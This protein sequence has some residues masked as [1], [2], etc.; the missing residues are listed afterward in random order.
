MCFQT[1]RSWL[2]WKCPTV[3]FQESVEVNLLCQIEIQKTRHFLSKPVNKACIFYFN[4]SACTKTLSWFSHLTA[5]Q[6]IQM[7]AAV[8]WPLVPLRQEIDGPQAEQLQTVCC[9]LFKKKTKPCLD[10]NEGDWVPKNWCFWTV[11]LEKTLKNPLDCKEVLPVHPNG[12]Q[13][14]IFIGRTH[15]EAETPILWS[16]HVKSWLTGKDPDAGRDWGQEEKGTT[17]DE[18]AG[19]HHRLDGR[20]FEWTPGVGDGQGG[21][22]CCDSW[23]RESRTRLSDWTELNWAECHPTISSSVIPFSCLQSFPASGSFPMS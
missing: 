10:K 7:Q 8:Q 6:A 9:W 23:G 13:L 20:E 19:W 5:S 1:C 2:P 12:N 22:A 18:M 21:L 3:I 11:V 14:W 15:T 17:E 16:P 4:S